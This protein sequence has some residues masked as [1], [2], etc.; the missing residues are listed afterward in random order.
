MIPY[1]QVRDVHLELST[2]CNA[3]C[4]E[5]PRNFHGYPHNDGY[6]EVNFTLD[7]ARAVFTPDFLK[8]I[9]RV[10]VNGNFGDFVMNPES[11][12]IFRYF[13][14]HNPKIDIV[15]STNGGARNSEFWHELGLMK[16]MVMFCIDGLADTHHLYRQNTRWETVIKNAKTFIDAG[17]LAFWKMIKFKHNEHQ[18]DECVKM[19][20]EL[21]FRDLTLVD[22]GRNSGP[23]FDKNGDLVRVLGDY[24]H[25][26]ISFVEF[27]DMKRSQAGKIYEEPLSDSL[28]C[29]SMKYQQIYIAANGEVYPCCYLGFYPKTYGK[30]SWLSHQNSLI[31]GM[32]GNNNAIEL[33]IE[34]AMDW[35]DQVRKSWNLPSAEEG[36]IS[37]CD[38]HCGKK[39]KNDVSLYNKPK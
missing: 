34:A 18:I 17:G 20:R 27:L 29:E 26:E 5:C 4:P 3:I 22:H 25:P 37:L 23:V 33:G 16:P 28:D 15:I 14:S 13:K 10:M 39:F 24:Q 11:L 19:S 2:L 8:Q 38:R 32:S 9:T 21:G 36:R 35:F 1:K 12:E 7:H 31:A 6:P 30:G